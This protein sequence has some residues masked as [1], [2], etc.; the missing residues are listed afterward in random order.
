MQAV[1]PLLVTL[2][3][4]MAAVLC[5]QDVNARIARVESGLRPG[6][7]IAGAAPVRYSLAD[8]MKQ[9]HVPAVS[10]AVV[11]EGRI[12]WARAWGVMAAGESKSTTPDTLFQAASISKP[13]A[14][15]AVLR[16]VQE[17]KLSLDE[18]VN[19]RLKTWK[20]PENDFTKTEKVTLRRILSHTAGLTVSGFP[21][22]DTGA[23]LPSLPQILDGTKPANTSAVRVTA[24]PGSAW[25]YSGGGYVLAQLLVTGVV[26]MP[27]PEFMNRTVLAPLGMS[28]STYRQPLPDSRRAEAA[29]GHDGNGEMVKGRWHV[30]PEMAPAGLWTTPSD[31]A[32]VILAVQHPGKVLTPETTS[33]MTTEIKNRYALGFGAQGKG[34]D[35]AFSH[36][37]ANE[38][39]RCALFGYVK[40][41][42]GA[43]V[44][45]NSDEGGQIAGE[46]LRSIAA[47]YGWPDYK[48]V[49]KKVAPVGAEVLRRYEG[50]YQFAGGPPATVVVFNGKL[51]VTPPGGS[52]IDLLASSETEFFSPEGRMPDLHFV[53]TPDGSFDIE[54]GGNVARR[55]R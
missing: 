4:A 7:A 55:M 29:A 28:H 46:V 38:G 52:A 54:T 20:L 10:I 50:E 42:Q 15:M 45:T 1:M 40:R 44:M 41:G 35:L 37:G 27:F 13:V 49:E 51:V 32:R 3:L 16:L 22:Y 18:D 47:E 6:V 14:A 23:D 43:V 30:Y 19:A 21:G 34:D 11:N 12:E 26:N 39:F 33:W 5:G 48:Q 8:R 53:K 17:G 36:G 2:L 9:L 24:I 31:L 25:R